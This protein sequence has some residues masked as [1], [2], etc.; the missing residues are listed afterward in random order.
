MIVN[1]GP[2]AGSGNTYFSQPNSVKSRNTL[3]ATKDYSQEQ[4]PKLG[5]FAKSSTQNF[6]ATSRKP[7]HFQGQSRHD[8]LKVP[9]YNK[10]IKV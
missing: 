9:Y 1:Q 3:L 2:L 7:I 8:R 6:M 10:Q 5:P 4:P